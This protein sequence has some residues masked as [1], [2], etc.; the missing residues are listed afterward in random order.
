MIFVIRTR[1][2]PLRSRPSR[3]LM[4][5]A[6]TVVTLA[7]LLPFTPLGRWF[8]FVAPPVTLLL[9]LAAM[10][11]CYLTLAEIVKRGFYRLLARRA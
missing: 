10:L 1:R 7:V 6:V 9:T 5:A 4:I 11:L 8:G 3:S 2:N